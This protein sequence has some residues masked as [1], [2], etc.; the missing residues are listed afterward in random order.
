M[1]MCCVH[2]KSRRGIYIGSTSDLRER[3]R[4]HNWGC[5]RTPPGIVPG[6]WPGMLAFVARKDLAR[7]S[8]ISRADRVARFSARGC[9]TS[10]APEGAASAAGPLLDCGRVAIRTAAHEQLRHLHDCEART[11]RWTRGTRVLPVF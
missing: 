4:E 1:F 2:S 9:S 8:A 3:L 5:R 7:S 10:V 6:R 11:P